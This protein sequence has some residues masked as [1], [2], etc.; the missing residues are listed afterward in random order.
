MNWEAIGAS[1][2][3][4][5]ALAVIVTLIYLAIQLNQKNRM[6]K[7]QV[8]QSRGAEPETSFVKKVLTSTCRMNLKNMSR[9]CGVF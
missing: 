9:W 5:A 6:A 1:A 2:E 4:L 7:V 8:M 3:A